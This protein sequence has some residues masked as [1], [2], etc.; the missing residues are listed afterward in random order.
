MGDLPHTPGTRPSDPRST[1]SLAA[2]ARAGNVEDLARL[3]EDSLPAMYVWIRG[4]VGNGL[5]VHVDAEDLLQEVWLRAI[6]RFDRYDPQRS[7]FQTW[8]IGIAKNVLLE[9]L[10]GASAARHTRAGPEQGSSL[11][12]V[13]DSV[14]T[15]TRAVARNED[16]QRML[17]F[18][19]TLDPGERLLLLGHG[20][21]GLTLAEIGLQLGV[22][23]EAAGKRWQRLVARL[24]E[25]A[26]W[27]GVLAPARG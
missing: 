15:L 23:A 26:I 21:E 24:R 11:G 9:S 22:S 2:G 7:S 27:S 16:V 14:T 8:L 5:G 19:E 17:A 25:P 3:Y 1:A 4:R 10:R 18:V 12:A 13:P 20:V 6:P